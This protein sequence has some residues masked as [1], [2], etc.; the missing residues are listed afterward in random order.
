LDPASSIEDPCL[1]KPLSVA[2]LLDA[3]AAD[4]AVLEALRAKG[5]PALQRVEAAAETRGEARGEAKGK[6]SAILQ[7]LEARG[8]AVSPSQRQEILEC[9]DLDRLGRWLRRAAVASSADEVTSEP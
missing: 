5:N 3:A 6:T 8:I 4:D 1:V 2:A 7:V 9:S